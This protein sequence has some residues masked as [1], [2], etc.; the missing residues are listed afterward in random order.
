MGDGP[1]GLH[2]RVNPG[3][4]ITNLPAGIVTFLF[5]DIEGSTRLWERDPAAMRRAI[6]RHNAILGQAIRDHRG[7]HFK[8]IGD[9]YQAA[10]FTPMDAVSAA[11]IAQQAIAREPWPDTGPIRVRMALHMGAA[12]P[13]PTR[14]LPRSQPESPG[15]A[16]VRR[17]WR[18]GAALSGGA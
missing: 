6:E 3:Q 12:E 1:L 17:A 11:V 16:D 5:T 15:P 14:G 8:T 7:H 9:A 18:P 10:F 13:S 2:S 4:T